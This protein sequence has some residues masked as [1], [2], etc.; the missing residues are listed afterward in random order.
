MINLETYMKE[1][2]SKLQDQ[3]DKMTR[4]NMELEAGK[5]MLQIHQAN[6]S[7]T[8]A[9]GTTTATFTTKNLEIDPFKLTC[10]VTAS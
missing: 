6:S 5:F 2:I 3:L 1:K 7:N 10:R 4:K 8:T 9:C